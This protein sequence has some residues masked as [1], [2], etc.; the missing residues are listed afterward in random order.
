MLH[1]TD[2]KIQVH[3][4]YCVLALLLTSLLQREL[5]RKGESISINRMLEELAGIRETLII[6]PAQARTAPVACGDLSNP[7]EPLAAAPLFSPQPRTMRSNQSLG[8]TGSYLATSS[9]IIAYKLPSKYLV[10]S[11]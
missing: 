10:N 5:A 6:Y 4:F 11:R 2:S 7:E 3:A 9:K 1:W 8:H